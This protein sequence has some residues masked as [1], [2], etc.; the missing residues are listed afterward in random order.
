MKKNILWLSILFVLS[1]NLTISNAQNPTYYIKTDSLEISNINLEEVQVNSGRE[2]YKLRE[3]PISISLLTSGKLKDEGVTGIKDLTSLV[4]NFFMPDYGSKLTSPVYIRG[5]GS[6]IDSPSAGL[7]IDNVPYFDKSAFDFDLFDIES[8]EVLRGPQGTLYGRNTIGGLIN[9]NTKS[10]MIHQGSW[11]TLS[12]GNYGLFSGNVS[13]YQKLNDATAFSLTGNYMQR[14]AYHFNEFLNLPVDAITSYGSRARFIRS[15]NS[16]VRAEITIGFEKLNQGGYP[17]ALFNDSLNKAEAIKY[18]HISSFKRNM[19]TGALALN[20]TNENYTLNYTAG[21]QFLEGFQEI[22]QDFTPASI[23]FVT[24]EQQQHLFSQE[25]LVKSANNSRLK[26]TNGAFWFRQSLI[27]YVDANYLADAVPIYAPAI[28]TLHR[29]Y[30]NPASGG[31]L[32]HQSTLEDLF[33]ENLSLTAG[34]RL[35][36]EKTILD[37]STH[38]I[39]GDIST[40]PSELNSELSFFEFLP[41]VALKY[42]LSVGKWA[43][44][45]AARG[46]K[47]GGFNTSFER[48]E[49]RSFLPEYTWNYE[50]GLKMQWSSLLSADM[51]VFY[52]NWKDQQIYQPLPS[53]RGSMLKNAGHSFSRGAEFSIK[54]NSISGFNITVDYGFTDAR[55]IDYKLDS[56]TNYNGN[57]IPYVPLHTLS[58]GGGKKFTVNL[59]WLESISALANYQITGKHYWNEENSHFQDGYGILN[60]RIV[61]AGKNLRLDIWAKNITGKSYHSFFF[62]ALRNNYVQLGNPFTVGANLTLNF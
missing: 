19:A 62:N 14:D 16:K 11:L 61:L 28:M 60:S 52:I 38:R 45:S 2:N 58:I 15:I 35:D 57:M 46:Y 48:D 6:R 17:Y 10:P 39:I 42:A 43:Y 29:D 1:I 37:Y 7:Y 23:I 31:A 32:F 49:D 5:I 22:D 9:I 20:Y 36:Y 24:Q 3:L 34:L 59:K 21:Y 26:W 40:I 55:F 54:A 33:I 44:I 53:G 8:I 47:T 4:P 27:K 25:I 30:N 12:G 56:A 50:A 18:N 41:K 51:S 13:H